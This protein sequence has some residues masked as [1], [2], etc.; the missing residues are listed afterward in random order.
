MEWNERNE[1]PKHM[2]KTRAIE[3]ARLRKLI[4]FEYKYKSYFTNKRI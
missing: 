2:V 3:I 1:W 4:P